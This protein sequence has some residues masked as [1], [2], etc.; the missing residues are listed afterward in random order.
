MNGYI[1][2]LT[3]LRGIAAIFIVAHH[4][5]GSFLPELG[6]SIGCFAPFFK[7]CYL[8][9]DFFFVLSGYILGHVY[10][11]AFKKSVP[12]TT[13]RRFIA[14]RFSRIYPVHFAVLLAFIILAC[15]QTEFRSGQ[16][17]SG[18]QSIL[19][20]FTNIGLLQ[21]FHFSSWNEPAWSISAEWLMYLGLPAI[22]CFFSSTNRVLDSSLFALAII[23][24]FTLNRISGT[25]DFVGW[26]ALL[27]CAAE[28]VMG[29]LAY[30]HQQNAF[31]AS[32]ANRSGSML[33]IWV[34]VMISLVLDINHAITAV[35][36]PALIIVCSSARFRTCLFAHSWL[37]FLGEIS[38]SIYM[39]HWFL[40]KVI[41]TAFIYMTGKEVHGNFQPWQLL[42]IGIAFMAAVV[43]AAWL[44]YRW[45]EVPARNGLKTLF[46]FHKVNVK[47]PVWRAVDRL[48]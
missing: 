41:D 21:V 35:M 33:V 8:W 32:T 37:V 11:D 24:V 34:A 22:I 12:H 1:P 44:V 45:I 43:F 17:F 16:G 9:V 26:K 15:F 19:S 4:T 42:G 7:K 10:Q 38:Y 47:L 25:L 3:S 18:R 28:M 46:A 48:S 23:A 20:I 2:A 31:I 29:I 27:R 39:I 6:T 13:Y 30:K 40:W 14:A 5:V 36:F